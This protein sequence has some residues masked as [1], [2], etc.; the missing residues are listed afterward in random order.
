VRVGVFGAGAIGAYLGVR[1][2]AA[3][4]PVVLV[5]RRAL[6]DSAHALVAVDLTGGRH[7]PA[8]R[9]DVFEDAQ[10][11]S[12]VDVCLVTVKRRDTATAGRRLAEVLPRGAAVGTL[13][14]GVGAADELRAA[15]LAGPV[16]SGLVTFN[17]VGEGGERRQATPGPVLVEDVAPAR[18]LVE[19]LGRA[20][21]ESGLRAD[22]AAHQAGKLLLN[23]NNGVCAAVG[24]SIAETVAARPARRVFADCIDEGL[25]VLAASGQPVRAEGA[26]DPRAL[27]WLLRLPDP[28]FRPIARRRVRVDPRARSSTLQDLDRGRPT[29]IE[30]LNGEIVRRG[31]AAG[32]ATPANRAVRDAV[33][34]REAGAPA[35]GPEALWQATRAAPSA[36]LASGG[37]AL[38]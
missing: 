21:V 27:R 12:E 23:L 33:R 28:I 36:P 13:Q 3:G 38:R 15:G 4:V 19:A 6:V 2:S 10:A 9:L 35:L 5:G 7:R 22:I 29:E 17:V 18:P 1:L 16:F 14:N 26:L 8:A 20:G 34:A 24:R 37:S 30:V 31:E 11:L 32:L 25:R